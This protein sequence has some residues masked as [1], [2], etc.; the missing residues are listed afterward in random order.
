MSFELPSELRGNRP[1]FKTYLERALHDDE[2][3]IQELDTIA[4]FLDYEREYTAETQR[5]L[6][7][8]LDE[9]SDPNS[10]DRRLGRAFQ[11]VIGSSETDGIIGGV[12]RLRSNTLRD[13]WAYY[14]RRRAEEAARSRVQAHRVP[15]D[16]EARR[17]SLETARPIDIPPPPFR[18]QRIDPRQK[19]RRY[20]ADET[21]DIISPLAYDPPDFALY[22]DV[23]LDRGLSMRELHEI[24]R[25]FGYER[26]YTPEIRSRISTLLRAKNRNVAR[27]FQQAIRTPETRDV[28]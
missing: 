14:D 25:F 19:P 17:F 24:A 11:R 13:F 10:A 15:Q 26:Q 6:A 23:I 22:L 9:I 16:T 12:R 2:L 7:T 3:S 27:R 4:E 18:E 20:R 28:L 8:M 21:G 5:K 1:D